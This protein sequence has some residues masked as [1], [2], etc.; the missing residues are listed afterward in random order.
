MLSLVL[1]S[2]LYTILYKSF[3]I[4]NETSLNKDSD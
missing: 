2:D 1:S 3:T 4:F